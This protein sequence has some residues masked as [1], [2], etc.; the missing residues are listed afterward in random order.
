VPEDRS[1]GHVSSLDAGGGFVVDPAGLDVIATMLRGQREDVTAIAA[2]LRR[3]PTGS[4]SILGEAGAHR[5]YT[6]FFDAWV[7]ELET[8]A[9]GIA[10]LTDRMRATA[11][12]Y[13]HADATEGHRFGPGPVPDSGPPPDPGAAAPL[14]TG[15]VGRAL[16]APPAQNDR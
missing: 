9:G 4:R 13:H 1:D 15:A 8:V 10:E 3:L 14:P 12:T 11:T 6:N 7:G 16:E 5:A 2:A